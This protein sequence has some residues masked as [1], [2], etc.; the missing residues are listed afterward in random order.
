MKG[1]PCS[2]G[3]FGSGSSLSYLP[4]LREYYTHSEGYRSRMEAKV[5]SSSLR[6][7]IRGAARVSPCTPRSRNPNVL[8]L[9]PASN[10]NEP[11]E[12]PR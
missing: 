9:I 4:T 2:T 7:H 1:T 3:A 5:N 6:D 12:I 10:A 11:R 8:L